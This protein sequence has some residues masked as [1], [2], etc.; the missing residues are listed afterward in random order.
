MSAL[1][2]SEHYYYEDEG[3]LKQ[4]FI[5]EAN[6][7]FEDAIES[8]EKKVDH[9]NHDISIA[10][11]LG[12]F[13][14]KELSQEDRHVQD[15]VFWRLNI[16]ANTEGVEL[17]DMSAKAYCEEETNREDDL[18]PLGGGYPAIFEKLFKCCQGNVLFNTRVVGIDMTGNNIVLRTTDNRVFF[19]RRVIS[20]I[21]LG[22]L[23]RNLI[24]WNPPLPEPYQ[25]SIMSIGNG[26]AN[27]LFV[28][29]K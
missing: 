11:A 20:S 6:E 3:P 9:M 18:V 4:K 22:I 19:A 1:I 14:R 7:M 15:T 29:F 13:M 17:S 8:V 24:Q 27:K 10:E 23:Q 25:R 2:N 28:S 21:P 5:D 16:E 26:V 12:D